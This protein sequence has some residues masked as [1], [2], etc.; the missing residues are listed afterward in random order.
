[1][2]ETDRLRLLAELTSEACALNHGPGTGKIQVR[3]SDYLVLPMGLD[4]GDGSEICAREM[5]VP[6]C[7]DCAQALLGNEWTLL[8]CFECCGSQ[9]INRQLAKNRYRH[10]VL[11]LRGCPECSYEFGGL[12]FTDE[13][14]GVLGQSEL[15]GRQ[16]RVDAA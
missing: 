8:Y 4:E 15:L 14:S 1:M 9:W 16:I 2:H 10:H 6:V 5:V 3:A 11:W 13:V 7:I 12:Y